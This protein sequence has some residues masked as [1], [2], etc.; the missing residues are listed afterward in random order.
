MELTYK[1]IQELTV[2][3]VT[4]LNEPDGYHFRRFTERQVDVIFESDPTERNYE[5]T[6]I[7]L[8]FHTDATKLT[9][10]T[11]TKGKYEVL[12]NG[13]TAFWE[14]F[15]DAAQFE[16]PL[17]GTD[18][19][20][21]IILPSHGIGVIQSVI[22]EDA[23][24]ASKHDHRLKLAFYGDSITQGWNSEKDSQSY[25]WLTSRF[26]DADSRIYGIG[27]TTFIPAFPED[28][29]FRPDAVIVAMGTNDYGRNKTME[30]IKAD[31]AAYLKNM[32]QANPGS[33]LFCVTPTWRWAG[34]K[35]KAAGTL[36]EVRREIAQVA[37]DSGY[38]VIDGLSMMPQRFEYYFDKGLHPNEQGFSSYA[39]NLCKVLCRYL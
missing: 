10:K 25:A 29:G 8:D 33:Q 15:E 4:V 35:P 24:Y 13:L 34:L 36:A 21:T 23:T 5:T 27:G 30:Q 19:R 6:G 2:G 7:R 12:I 22:L 16:V 31:C 18:N 3:A 28:T 39:L 20:V 26:F 38:T 32:E 37:T 9:V 14:T 17:V 11:A 1:Q